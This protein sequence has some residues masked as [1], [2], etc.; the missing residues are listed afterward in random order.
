[1]ENKST[2]IVLAIAII[3]IGGFLYISNSGAIVTAQGTSILKVQPDKVS[4]NLNIETRGKTSQEAK[5]L[6][7]EILD[8]V[9]TN[10]IKTGLDKDEVKTVNFNIYP[11]YTYNDG[12]RKENGF[13]AQ[14]SLVVETS[15]FS[16]VAAIVDASI[17]GGALVSYINFEL[18]EEKQSEFKAKSLE[19]AG[20]DARKKAE[21]TASGVDKKLGKLVSVKSQDFNYGPIMYFEAGAVKD[22][23]AGAK[24]AALNIAPK[25]MEVSATIIVE[26]RL[27]SF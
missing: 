21:A 1:M 18:S 9:I 8:K 26:Y 20:K 27:K 7:D 22:S 3:L 12:T 19:E 5:D 13:I 4:I 11:D 10:L 6:H 25:D 24:E 15:D 14:E 23:A 2:I 16:K 17:E